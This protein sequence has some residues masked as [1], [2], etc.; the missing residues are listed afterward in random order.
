MNK[1]IEKLEAG[2][3]IVGMQ[4]FYRNSM[5]SADAYF[6]VRVMGLAADGG[7]VKVRVAPTSG[8]GE[9]IVDPG[10]LINATK[11]AA[12]A[13]QDRA[14]ANNLYLKITRR[15]LLRARREAL[16]V[17]YD[18][19]PAKDRKVIDQELTERAIK[20]IGEIDASRIGHFARLVS[21]LTYGVKED[22]EE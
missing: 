3:P 19:L 22:G 16:M 14:A 11:E 1:L 4:M 2:E 5:Y 17:A 15:D 9:F 18:A 6:T 12:K 10:D 7:R 20:T 13:V 8:Y 21:N